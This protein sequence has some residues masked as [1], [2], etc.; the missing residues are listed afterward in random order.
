[1]SSQTHSHHNRHSSAHPSVIHVNGLMRAVS[2]FHHLHKLLW[3]IAVL[4]VS[5]ITANSILYLYMASYTLPFTYVNGVN[6]G[7]MSNSEAVARL[8]SVTEA[9][10]IK[11]AVEGKDNVYSLKDLGIN[12]DGRLT[13]ADSRK[14]EGLASLP[15]LQLITSPSVNVIP[16]YSL[17]TVAL[18]DVA[19]ELVDEETIKPVESKIVIDDTGKLTITKPLPGE[20]IDVDIASRQ[21]YETISGSSEIPNEIAVKP[22]ILQ[23][24]SNY[25]VLSRDIEELNARFNSPV[26]IKDTSGSTLLE[27]SEMKLKELLEVDANGKL[28]FS[29]NNLEAYLKEEAALYFFKPPIHKRINGGVVTTEGVNGEQLDLNGSLKVM[30]DL[31]GNKENEVYLPSKALAFETITDGVYPKTEMGLHALINDF[32]NEKGGDY[33]IIVHQLTNS[34]LRATHQGSISS[35]P[36]STYK[37]FIAYAALHASETGEITLEDRTSKGTVRECM[38]EMI[39]YSTD[40]CAFAIQDYMGW[41]RID[42]ILHAAGFKNTKLNNEDRILDK[43]T[44]PQDEFKLLKGLYDGTLLNRENTEHLLTLMKEQKW[45]SGIPGGSTPAI[46]ADKV[47][48]YSGWI[49]DIGIVYA[50]H[51]DYIIVAISDGGSFWEINDLSRRVYNF[52]NR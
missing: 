24:K 5:F 49:N 27:I 39:H 17:D 51:D 20:R 10:K 9:S 33:R 42:D 47:G 11:I 36:A 2:D 28:V 15:L 16:K 19:S 31:L 8:S 22:Q 14:V 1:M 7:L 46:V 34:K 35:I 40:F 45:R 32:D 3:W 21:I 29:K 30:S 12:I 38:Y 13:L 6:V 23:P 50:G 37:A 18:R 26:L 48:F 25:S 44:T 41:Q 4:L 52:F 43:Y